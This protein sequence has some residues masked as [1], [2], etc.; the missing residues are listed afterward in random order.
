M[1]VRHEPQMMCINV[2][3]S[4]G[5]ALV[6]QVADSFLWTDSQI[7]WYNPTGLK[8]R[9]RERK[10]FIMC[11]S[12]GGQWRAAE[13]CIWTQKWWCDCDVPPEHI[14]SILYQIYTQLPGSRKTSECS[15][16]RSGWQ[17]AWRFVGSVFSVFWPDGE[18][19]ELHTTTTLHKSNTIRWD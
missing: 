16:H 17:T 11:V 4:H 2:N 7:H 9:D 6:C 18:K 3:I 14:W 5:W 12:S 10:G 8:E 1:C 19:T 13:V 15:A